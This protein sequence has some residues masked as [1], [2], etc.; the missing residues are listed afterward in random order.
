MA[1]TRRK[2]A[3]NLGSLVIERFAASSFVALLIVLLLTWN[4]NKIQLIQV[5][6]SALVN[7]L[8][9]Q[10]NHRLKYTLDFS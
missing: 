10:R 1:V 2:L 7:S 8:D 9:C 5:L 3:T 6:V 4:Q